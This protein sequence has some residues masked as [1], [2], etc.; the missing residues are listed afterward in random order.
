MKER[1]GGFVAKL[2]PPFLGWVFFLPFVNF[3]LG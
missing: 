2:G 3:G 1:G